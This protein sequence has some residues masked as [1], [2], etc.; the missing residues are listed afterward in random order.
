MPDVDGVDVLLVVA[1]VADH[2]RD[3]GGVEQQQHEG[4]DPADDLD[5]PGHVGPDREH[6]E[7]NDDPERDDET[8]R[9]EPV[10][11][12][13]GFDSGLQVLCH[14]NPPRCL[15]ATVTTPRFPGGLFSARES[16]NSFPAPKLLL[17]VGNT[18][19]SRRRLSIPQKR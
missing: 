10:E 1:V 9:P 13:H 15:P 18:A 14:P 12:E 7:E 11:R 5:A 4:G 16:E 8:R 19:A 17:P 2:R 3:R 6:D